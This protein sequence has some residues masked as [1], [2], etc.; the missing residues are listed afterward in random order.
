MT[1]GPQKSVIRPI[2]GLRGLTI[3]SVVFL[4]IVPMTRALVPELNHW[5]LLTEQI[6]FRMD[7][8]FILSGFI[9]SYVYFS[10][11]PFSL[12]AYRE[13]LRA[14]LIRVYPGYVFTLAVLG[15]A[16]GLS[17]LGRAPVSGIYPLEALVPILTLTQS[18][19]F[20]TWAM[21]TWNS[22]TWFLSALWF[23]WLAVF[24][25]IWIL[26]P[27]LRGARQAVFWVFAPL[28]VWALV[29]GV[30]AIGDFHRI[31]R[32]SLET[33]SGGVLYVCFKDNCGFVRL[34]RSHPQAVAAVFLTGIAAIWFAP[35]DSV[36]IWTNRVLLLMTPLLLMAMTAEQGV[37]VR[38][39]SSRLLLWLGDHSYALFVSHF[40]AIKL[41]FKALHTFFPQVSGEGAPFWARLAAYATYL[42][43]IVFFAFL[44]RRFIELPCKDWLSRRP[45]PAATAGQPR[46]AL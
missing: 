10:K 41:V 26:A 31:V 34:A 3:A 7:L 18:W 24:P 38:V 13:F 5:T 21:W 4:H 11:G 35:T 15:A 29:S 44:L 16:H 2:N 32:V 8:F 42:G 9:L 46:P 43:V 20:A 23:G 27:K 17:H 39:M 37:V 25:L 22:P 28:L 19:P 45:A 33:F 36:I 6:Q 12:S 1:S 14:R 30:S 40:V